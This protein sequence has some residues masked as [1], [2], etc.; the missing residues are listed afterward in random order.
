MLASLAMLRAS[1]LL[2]VLGAF[3]CGT[4]KGGKLQTDTPALPYKAPDIEELTGVSE[5]DEPPAPE[6][7]KE[8]PKPEPKAETAPAPAPVAATPAPAKPATTPAKPAQPAGTPAKPAP[9]TPAKPA[10][11]TPTAPPPPKK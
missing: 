7:P 1:L 9:A 11:G 10:T 4:P 3:A 8:A 6:E 2:V 5:E